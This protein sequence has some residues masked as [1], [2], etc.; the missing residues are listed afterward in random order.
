MAGTCV[1]FRP[2]RHDM[3]G[4]PPMLARPIAAMPGDF[5]GD[6]VPDIAVVNKFIDGNLQDGSISVL[7]ASADGNL[8]YGSTQVIEGFSQWAVSADFNED[9]IPDVAAVTIDSA[10][11]FKGDGLG[12]FLPQVRIP[13]QFDP[14]HVVAADMN[15]DAHADLVVVQQWIGSSSGRVTVMLG[16]GAGG[17][18]LMTPAPVGQDPRGAAVGDFNLDGKLDV[19]TGNNLSNDLTFLPG[20]GNGNFGPGRTTGLGASG[21]FPAAADFN[22]DG[23]L[24]LV[25]TSETVAKP[26]QTLFGVGDGTF[27]PNAIL[28]SG[29]TP[30]NP[31]LCDFDHDGA[32]DIAVPNSGSGDVSLMFGNGQGSFEPPVHVG[33]DGGPSQA[34]VTDLNGDGFCDLVTANEG[35][36][37]VSVLVGGPRGTVGT[38]TINVGRAPLGAAAADFNHDGHVD[39]AVVNRDDSTVSIYRGDGEGGLFQ[40]QVLGVGINPVAIKAADLDKDGFADLV[41]ADQGIFGNSQNDTIDVVMNDTTGGFFL[42]SSMTVGD[43]PLDVETGDFNGD[44]WPDIVVANSQS[45]K[46]SVFLSDG[47]GGFGNVKNIRIGEFQRWLAVADLDGDGLQDLAV[48]LMNQNAVMPVLG[49]GAG[50]FHMGTTINLGGTN[51][52]NRVAVGDLNGDGVGDLV[53]I[54]RAA[55]GYSQGQLAVLIGN[56]DATY[57]EPH[58]RIPT[59]VDPEGLAILDLDRIGGLDVAVANRFNNDVMALLGDGT[60]NLIG[61]TDRYG[62][63][64][65]PFALAQA[66]FNEDF[67]MDV[68]AVNFSGNTVSVLLNNYPVADQLA[69]VDVTGGT[70]ITWAP[71]PGAASYRVYRGRLALLDSDNYGQCLNPTVTATQYTDSDPIAVG[72]GFFYLVTAVS[73]GNEGPLGYSSSCVSRPNFS[74]CFVP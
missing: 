27:V 74:P 24:D 60:G 15:G 32:L 31:L 33:T 12:S 65:G 48:A 45:D 43:V 50:G 13:L 35:N 19:V 1:G 20:L 34:S 4:S 52:I 67:R 41:V 63:G 46:F 10:L 28:L 66:D 47:S 61:E 64:N 3:R 11:I 37:S 71:V 23:V 62:S 51:L 29:D 2:T 69:S 16:D 53:T 21:G 40:S 25:M 8:T 5:N 44:T 68:A 18:T 49:T 42:Q 59:G 56:G 30:R 70:T 73:N 9:M 22:G 57:T 36:N 14:I 17:F 54:S 7:T 38:P 55:D 58:P 26:A 39:L 72:D 6:G